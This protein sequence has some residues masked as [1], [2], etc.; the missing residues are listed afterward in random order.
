MTTFMAL[1]VWGRSTNP[2][3][4]A[5]YVEPVMKHQSLIFNC[6]YCRTFLLKVTEHLTQ[7]IWKI[8]YTSTQ[9]YASISLGE[10]TEACQKLAHHSSPQD[11]HWKA[12]GNLAWHI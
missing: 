9:L 2:V 8:S 10:V 5:F 12:I 7:A 6:K 4:I 3:L 11:L 1:R